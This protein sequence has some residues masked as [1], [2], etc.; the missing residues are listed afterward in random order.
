MCGIA[1]IVGEN[2]VG[3][4]AAVRRMLDAMAHRGPDSTGLYAAPS[5]ACVLGHCRLAVIDLSDAS[6]QPM[7]TADGRYAYVCNGE[8]YDFIEKRAELERQGEVFQSS[9]DAEV[10][11]KLLARAGAA[12]LPSCNGMFA[13]ALWDEQAQSLLLARDIFGQKQVYY[14]RRNG[15]LIFASE[16]RALLASGMVER[17]VDPLGLAGYL[18]FGAVPSPRTIVAGVELLPAAATL[19]WQAGAVE[20]A[21]SYWRPPADK[22]SLP[23]GALRDVFVRAVRRHLVSDAPLGLFLSGGIDSSAVAVAA[24]RVS[25][26]T[27]R[28]LAVVFP[29]QT[30]HSEAG[31]ARAIAELI[32]ARHAEI[33]MTDADMLRLLEPAVDALDQPTYDAV[34]TYIV[35]RAARQAGLTV[36][37]SG[38]GG[39]ELFG[40]YPSFRDVPRMAAW[41]AWLR[42]LSSA[43]ALAGAPC[44][45][46]H[47]RTSKAPDCLAAAGDLLQ[48]FLARRRLFSS[49]Q[50]FRLLAPSSAARLPEPSV[51]GLTGAD[52]GGLSDFIQ[53]FAPPDAVGLL[54]L[55]TY[56]AD[57][58][59]RDT[60]A[61]GMANTLEIRAPFLDTEFAAAALRLEPES[62]APA[63]IPKRRFV[64]A[65]GDWLPRANTH[66]KKQ[67]FV[68][69]M[70]V[71]M[72]GAMRA[73]VDAGISKLAA[74]ADWCNGEALRSLW[75]AFVRH[76]REVGWSRPWGLF[77]LGKYLKKHGVH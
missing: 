64:E 33:P 72:L 76:P 36:A 62:R 71:W 59:L 58:L 67:G 9:G 30:G 48:S 66:R 35:A 24:A 2:A 12:A 17:R 22:D 51:P 26:Q 74:T 53:G 52:I 16:V 54:E 45:A 27:L 40:G 18:S 77:V 15:L 3:R 20:P 44:G 49:R 75:R 1:G 21:R 69:P 23:P 42:H 32:G 41:P 60:D 6:A 38:L 7:R 4:Q 43:V 8:L 13:A 56:M 55:K 37:L 39:D 68:L 50:V 29:E 61:A 10:F 47:T 57:V 19:R 5:G 73:E 14:A 31:Y 65:M 34:N 70:D 11:F 63:E 25:G 46:W 28:T